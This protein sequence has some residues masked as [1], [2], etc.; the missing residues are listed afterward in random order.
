MDGATSRS[1][2]GHSWS[3][4]STQS[5]KRVHSKCRKSVSPLQVRVL[6]RL[7]MEYRYAADHTRADALSRTA[8]V[9]AR[10]L[11]D[12]LVQ[13]EAGR[14]ALVYALNARHFAILAPD[15]LEERMAISRELVDL[16]AARGDRELLLQSLPWR[17]ADLLTVGQSQAVD[18]AIDQANTLAAALRQLLYLWYTQLFRALRAL[19]HGEW[20]EGERLAEAAY[21]IGQRVQPGGAAVYLAVQQF[22][23]RLPLPKTT[24]YTKS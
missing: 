10:R 6:A 11:D 17:V 7:A 18:A 22:M 1:A 23:R 13:P 20:T 14:T 12:T 4:N 21:Q 19:M 8:L 9:Q 16:A 2:I 3:Q 15:T 5:Q 24:G